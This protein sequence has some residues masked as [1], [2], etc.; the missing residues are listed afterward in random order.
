MGQDYRLLRLG[1]MIEPD[2]ML[3]VFASYIF[4]EQIFPN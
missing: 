3:K 4:D 2:G 1:E